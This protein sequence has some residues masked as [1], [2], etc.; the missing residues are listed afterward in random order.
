MQLLTPAKAV[1]GEPPRLVRAARR[2]RTTR[3]IISLIYNKVSVLRQTAAAPVFTGTHI[4][5]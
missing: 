1:G 4:V 5:S 2:P 3:N